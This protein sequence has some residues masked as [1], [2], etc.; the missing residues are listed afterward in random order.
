VSD[1]IHLLNF[2][3]T[4]RYGQYKYE[5]NVY[6]KPDITL[7]HVLSAVEFQGGGKKNFITSQKTAHSNCKNKVCV[8][9]WSDS[10]FFENCISFSISYTHLNYTNV[11]QQGHT[12][13]V[14]TTYLDH[15]AQCKLGQNLRSSYR[16][17]PHKSSSYPLG[18]L[19]HCPAAGGVH[20]ICHKGCPK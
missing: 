3:I 18:H 20:L 8:I 11:K 16:K 17:V 12:P 2:E 14:D 13:T 7:L 6:N 15:Q 9:L 1:S 4:Q 19:A 10:Y 5:Y